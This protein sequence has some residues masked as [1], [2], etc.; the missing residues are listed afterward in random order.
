LAPSK[1]PITKYDLFL[2]LK[3]EAGPEVRRSSIL[4]RMSMQRSPYH[5]RS[6]QIINDRQESLLSHL[7]GGEA[8]FM[9]IRIA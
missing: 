5:C 6:L 3:K 9:H 8:S 2:V 4:L 1:V 7:K